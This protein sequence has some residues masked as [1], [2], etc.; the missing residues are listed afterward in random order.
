MT[1]FCAAHINKILYGRMCDD[2]DQQ[3]KHFKKII[4]RIYHMNL[5]VFRTPYSI[6]FHTHIIAS[7]Y[8]VYDDD[9]NAENTLISGSGD[10]RFTWNF[11]YKWISRAISLCHAH[12]HDECASFTCAYTTD[13]TVIHIIAPVVAFVIVTRWLYICKTDPFATN[14]GQCYSI[15][16]LP[17]YMRQCDIA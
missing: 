17:I 12:D 13:E 1:N 15:K 3:S 4:N 2:D 5:W 8:I 16:V 6:P 7:K 11:I 14:N 9:S 10:H